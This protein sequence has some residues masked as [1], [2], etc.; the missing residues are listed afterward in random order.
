MPHLNPDPNHDP[1][2]N[3][4]PD[5]IASPNPSP[6]YG[7]RLGRASRFPSSPGS[8]IRFLGLGL[9]LGV[10][11]GLGSGKVRRRVLPGVSD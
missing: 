10:G 11:L 1:S 9:G 3:L 4:N 8:A 2:Q 5:P 6:S 7:H